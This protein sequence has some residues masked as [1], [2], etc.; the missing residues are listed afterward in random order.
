[1]V[2]ESVWGKSLIVYSAIIIRRGMV[3]RMGSVWRRMTRG[4]NSS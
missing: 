2:F 4:L 3:L 1:M